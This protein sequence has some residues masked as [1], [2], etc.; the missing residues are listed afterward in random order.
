ML[1]DQLWPV[2]LLCACMK[3]NCMDTMSCTNTSP[4]TKHQDSGF[5]FSDFKTAKL[6][7]H[8]AA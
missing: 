2:A 5:S 6:T 3:T 4:H 8:N 1:M 7:Q